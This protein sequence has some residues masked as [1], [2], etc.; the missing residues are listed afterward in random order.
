MG[1]GGCIRTREGFMYTGLIVVPTIYS[2]FNK[3][4]QVL[5]HRNTKF[6]P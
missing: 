3:I 1:G 2:N 4:T 5:H 6:G